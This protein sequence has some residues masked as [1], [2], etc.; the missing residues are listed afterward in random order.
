[1]MTIDTEK[2][3]NENQD[4][5][6]FCDREARVPNSEYKEKDFKKHYMAKILADYYLNK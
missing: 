2:A 6:E 3:Y 1:M 5:R 4:F